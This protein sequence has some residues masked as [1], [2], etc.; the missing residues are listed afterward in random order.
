MAGNENGHAANKV[1][2][3]SHLSEMYCDNV[4]KAQTQAAEDT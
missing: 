4:Q 3:P 2:D 1:K